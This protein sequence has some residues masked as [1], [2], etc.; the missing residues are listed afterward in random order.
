LYGKTK[1]KVYMKAGPELGSALCGKNLIIKKSLYGL[2]TSVVRFLEYLAKSLLCFEYL[3][4]DL[5]IRK[6]SSLMLKKRYQMTLLCQ[7]DQESV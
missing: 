7:R 4:D 1:E 6:T 5:H 2:K 3:V